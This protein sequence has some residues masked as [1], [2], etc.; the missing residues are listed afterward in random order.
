MALRCLNDRK[1]PL[2]G[3]FSFSSVSVCRGHTGVPRRLR[4]AQ[5][6][7]E[8]AVPGEFSVFLPRDRYVVTVGEQ[9][10]WFQA[11]SLNIMQRPVAAV[12]A[13]SN[14]SKYW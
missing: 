6:V 1:G 8:V 5:E 12:S 14:A 11:M 10:E 2:R 7:V 3:F 13:L 4:T 9:T